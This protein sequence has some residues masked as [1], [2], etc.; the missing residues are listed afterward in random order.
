MMCRTSR[1][2]SIHPMDHTYRHGLYSCHDSGLRKVQERSTQHAMSSIFGVQLSISYTF[3]NFRGRVFLYHRSTVPSRNLKPTYSDKIRATRS[4]LVKT[5][6]P[7][8][9]PS[10]CGPQLLWPL[11]TDCH[12]KFDIV[13]SCHVS[14][15]RL[16]LEA[17]R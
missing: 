3:A 7:S 8:H 1:R 14:C 2:S 4:D 12:I 6:E 5:R 17:N 15:I 9:P 13:E 16:A 10:M 11:P